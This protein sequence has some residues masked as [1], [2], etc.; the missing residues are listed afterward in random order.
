MP[1][2]PWQTDI[3]EVYHCE[4]FL[5]LMQTIEHM[6]LERGPN[7]VWGHVIQKTRSCEQSI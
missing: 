3:V 5:R 7:A 2:A 1:E 6:D 4:G